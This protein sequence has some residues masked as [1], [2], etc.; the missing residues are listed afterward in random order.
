[1][2]RRIICL[3]LL[4][5]LIMTGC[6]HPTAEEPVTV[7]EP[8]YLTRVN[9][10]SKEGSLRDQFRIEYD[11]TGMPVKISSGIAQDQRAETKLGGAPI[12]PE[13]VQLDKADTTYKSVML[14]PC[15]EGTALLVAGSAQEPLWG[16]VLYGS[17]YTERK[18]YLT[19][20]TA[21]DGSYIAFF[22]STLSV[23]SQ[24]D[25]NL[26]DTSFPVTEDSD[27]YGYDAVLTALGTYVVASLHDEHAELSDMLFSNLYSA[28]PDKSNIGFTFIDIDSNG[29]MELLVGSRGKLASS[30]IYNLYAIYNGRIVNVFSGSNEVRYTISNNNEILIESKNA[31]G[32]DVFAAYGYYNSSLSLKD[33]IIQNRNERFHSTQSF[34]D[35]STFEEM[36]RAEADELQKQYVAQ[37]LEFTPIS[38]FIESAGLDSEA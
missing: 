31:A 27:Y 34:S 22:Y 19:K 4:L 10:Y 38:T 30:M 32:Q 14:A 21:K 20:V 35:E 15:D 23:A 11:P 1:M 12:M 18:G 5:A 13:G 2:N 8:Q 37:E 28:E 24:N 17:D 7:S 26:D 25:D 6:A 36:T 29:S 3:L 33:A 16:M 9:F